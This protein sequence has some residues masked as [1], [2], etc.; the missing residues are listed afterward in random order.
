MQA[1]ES[2]LPSKQGNQIPNE[3]ALKS[4]Q[5]ANSVRTSNGELITRQIHKKPY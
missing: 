1:K 4:R 3:C 5:N 2:N